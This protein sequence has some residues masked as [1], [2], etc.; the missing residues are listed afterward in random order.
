M[1]RLLVLI[2][3]GA[4][5]GF[6]WLSLPG[7]DEAQ[8]PDTPQNS[9][10]SGVVQYVDAE[11]GVVTITHAP[12]PAL[13]MTSMTMSYAVKDKRQLAGLKP[14]Q[15]IA[16]RVAFDGNDYLITDIR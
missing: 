9:S 16:F 1:K 15:K 4:F 14:R 5:A 7:L 3:V 13:G 11:Q 8:L 6:A 2:G 12:L 10:G